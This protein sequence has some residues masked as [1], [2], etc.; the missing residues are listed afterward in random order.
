MS[1]INLEFLKNKLFKLDTI[2]EQIKET[3]NKYD[4]TK[5]KQLM[6]NSDEKKKCFD[7]F[8]KI[9]AT[10]SKSEKNIN[11]DVEIVNEIKSIL[12][13]KINTYRSTDINIDLLDQKNLS[14]NKYSNIKTPK[15]YDQ[16]INQY[17]YLGEVDFDKRGKDLTKQHTKMFGGIDPISLFGIVHFIIFAQMAKYLFIKTYIGEFLFDIF[18]VKNDDN[19]KDK[20]LRLDA[21]GNE[22]LIKILHDNQYSVPKSKFEDY[23]TD[24]VYYIFYF[25]I[26]LLSVN[27]NLTTLDI[28]ITND[29]YN[30]TNDNT[31]IIIN[32]FMMYN[33][34][35]NMYV[36]NEQHANNEI[37]EK[38][39]QLYIK[40]CNYNKCP[41]VKIINYDMMTDVINMETT[42]INPNIF[43]I[44][45]DINEYD[46][47]YLLLYCKL[48]NI[49]VIDIKEMVY[50]KEM[51][52]INEL[53]TDKSKKILMKDDIENKDN[54]W[55]FDGTYFKMNDEI[56][57]PD[58]NQKCKGTF[59]ERNCDT[60]LFN[61]ILNND[62]Q[63]PDDLK[64]CISNIDRFDFYE[65]E[66][67]N[68]HPQ[69]ALKILKKF[70]FQVTEVFSPQY[71]TYLKKI[72]SIE[73]WFKY[74]E[75]IINDNA[76]MVNIKAN[77]K[78]LKYFELLVDFVNRQPR[79]L[80]KSNFPKT[81]NKKIIREKN[82]MGIYN[83]IELNQP[84]NLNMEQELNKIK[85]YANS[86]GVYMPIT[87]PEGSTFYP[88]NFNQHVPKYSIGNLMVGGNFS[89]D[90]LSK[91]KLDTSSFLMNIFNN[92]KKK[93]LNNKKYI[94]ETDEKHIID[95]ITSIGI[96][97]VEILEKIR[98]LV[99]YYNLTNIQRDNKESKEISINDIQKEIYDY[100]H[101]MNKIKDSEFMIID[102]FSKLLKSIPEQYINKQQYVPIYV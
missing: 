57:N 83:R 36:F 81:I 29:E 27:M 11:V 31:K 7:F 51:G 73:D 41:L 68:I 102:I 48:Q 77:T 69:I 98:Y 63:N 79:L 16:N 4:P 6:S 2:N 18:L 40:N 75:S 87:R 58:L 32:K 54:I 34:E 70:G 59:I 97:E 53:K 76:V 30:N 45:R 24:I 100:E 90:N 85:N 46:F 1:G 88:F 56:A 67:K 25:I 12:L 17:E 35:N 101:D 78:L 19:V 84:F 5:D 62:G 37:I 44:G 99:K 38:I 94:N 26:N 82:N 65:D 15:I 74:I 47:N 93:L 33:H 86:Y 61:C 50:N 14:Q 92:I 89:Y 66:L 80:N 8:D 55:Y 43:N 49:F 60:F 22:W 72:I 42:I 3:I 52:M 96:L 95:L 9:V 13:P 21:L 64:K 71:N 10:D 91:A 39:R 23:Y 20:A 28:V